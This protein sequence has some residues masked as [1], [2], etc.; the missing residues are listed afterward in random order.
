MGAIVSKR[1]A[2]M[3]TRRSGFRTTTTHRS[4]QA[5]S[6]NSIVITPNG[7]NSAPHFE[8]AGDLASFLMPSRPVVGVKW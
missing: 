8:V 1:R 7:T 5:L 4:L 6:K 3:R 2:P